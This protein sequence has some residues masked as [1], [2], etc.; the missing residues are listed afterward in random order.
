MKP[1]SAVLLFFKL[2]SYD[3]QKF[4]NWQFLGANF[5]ALTAFYAITGRAPFGGVNMIVVETTICAAP[6]LI[7]VITGEK[8]RNGNV[9]GTAISA[10]AASGTVNQVDSA[11]DLQHI[12]NC[13]LFFVVQ[14]LEVLHVTAVILQDRKSVV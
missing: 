6:H 1:Y 8:I 2:V 12:G 7:C 5:L 9:F 14:G 10:V 13:L 11:K 3:L 4:F